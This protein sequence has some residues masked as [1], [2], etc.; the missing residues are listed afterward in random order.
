MVLE[1]LAESAGLHLQRRIDTINTQIVLWGMCKQHQ[2][3]STI[4]KNCNV[5]NS[6]TGRLVNVR[7]NHR[8]DYYST[9]KKS[10]EMV[11]TNIEF[12]L[13]SQQK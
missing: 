10:E 6:P 9:T 12:S 8:M 2:S 11:S 4:E 13:Y 5:I 3:I 1:S 7:S